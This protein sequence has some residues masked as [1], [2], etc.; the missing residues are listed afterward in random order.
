MRVRETVPDSVLG[1][2]DEVVLI[3]LTPEALIARLRAGKIYP[4][5]NIDAA[6]N[7]FFRI[8]NLAA[9]REVSL[10][11]VAEDVESKRLDPRARPSRSG[12]ARSGSPPRC[13]R[14]S[15][16]GCSRWSA[17]SPARSAWCAAPGARRSGS[18]TDLDLLWVKP[19]GQPIEGE[20]ERQVTALRQLA[21]VLGATLLIEEHDDLVAG[22]GA[23]RPRARQHLHHGRRVAA[24]A[25]PGAAAR[26]A[27]A[28]ADATRPRPGSTC[29]SSPTAAAREEAE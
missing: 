2:A 16:S 20:V 26:A 24:P 1:T 18:G 6:L 8:E 13:R 27:A 21:S 11:Q 28:A 19:P 5:E 22:G 23:G 25:R 7:N 3:D 4:G 9:L 15:A 29:G 17:P 10:R 14:R 12:R